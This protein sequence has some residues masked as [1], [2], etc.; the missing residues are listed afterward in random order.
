MNIFIRRF[1]N[2]PQHLLAYLVR[3]WVRDRIIEIH[4]YKDATVYRV[5]NFPGGVS[6][7][8]HIFVQ[9][10]ASTR[11]LRHEY[12][13]TI[14]SKLLGWLYLPLVGIPSM[15]LVILSRLGLITVEQYYSL[16]PERWADRLGGNT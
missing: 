8:Y 9:H 7:G 14:Q 10:N 12:G 4:T 15:F 6:L 5:M 2:I 3:W 11:L 13:H 1:T 16:Y